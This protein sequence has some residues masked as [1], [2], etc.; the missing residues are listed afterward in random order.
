[1]WETITSQ[2]AYWLIT[3][4][5][6]PQIPAACTMAGWICKNKNDQVQG[7]HPDSRMQHE[8]IQGIPAE[9]CKAQA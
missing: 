5:A 4:L 8:L 1:M 2:L 6:T 3:Y 7:L 9:V